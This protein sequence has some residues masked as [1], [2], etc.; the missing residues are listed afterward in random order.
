MV[1]LPAAAASAAVTW[2]SVA[3]GAVAAWFAVEPGRG[4]VIELVHV[5]VESVAVNVVNVAAVEVSVV[6]V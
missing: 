5:S 6:R 3:C 4:S 2:T 1:E